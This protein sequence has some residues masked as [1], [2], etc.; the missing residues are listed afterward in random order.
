[1]RIEPVLF[2]E[3]SIELTNTQRKRHAEIRVVGV[4]PLPDPTDVFN[5]TVASNHTYY[6]ENVLVENCHDALQYLTLQVDE[7][8]QSATNSGIDMV[9]EDNRSW[10]GVV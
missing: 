6:A 4:R 7:G 1:M 3:K 9:W 2:V 10:A 5:L 8:V